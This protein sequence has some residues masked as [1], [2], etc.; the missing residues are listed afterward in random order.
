LESAQKLDLTNVGVVII[1]RDEGERLRR[2]LESIAAGVSGIVYV[3]SGSTDQSVALAES[4]GATVVELD[5]CIP[6]TAGRAR[7]TGLA[8]LLEM[9]PH[10]KFVQ[11]IDGDCGVVPTWWHAAVEKFDASSEIAAVCGRQMEIHRNATIYNRMIDIEWDTPIG[12]AKSCGGCTMFRVAAFR[13][14]GGFNSAVIAGEEPE[15]CVRIRSQGGVIH[16]IDEPMTLHDADMTRFSQW[17]MR[18]VRAGHAYAQ[19]KAL[20]GAPPERHSVRQSRSIWLWA[21]WLPLLVAVLFVPTQGWSLVLLA[22]YPVL[23]MRVCRHTR[24][25]G[26]SLYESTLYALFTVL[27]KW[28]QF[29]GQIKF[30]WRT[31]RR[32]QHTLI[33]HK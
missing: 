19:G 14:A 12:V 9:T 10:I 24:S 1:G 3:D 31:L 32:T 25:R 4:I 20:H 30:K 11:F 28:P 6:F 7:N 29:Y 26:K 22:G 18:N 15:L 16:R 2:C 23:A 17:W 8:R 21:F 5:T 13:A 33:E 27:G